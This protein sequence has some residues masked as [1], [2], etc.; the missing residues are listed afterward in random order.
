MTA[1]IGPQGTLGARVSYVCLDC[2]Q[3]DRTLTIY[4]LGYITYPVRYTGGG[5]REML[6]SQENQSAIVNRFAELKKPVVIELFETSLNCRTCAEVKQLLQEVAALSDLLTLET[7]NTITDEANVKWMN[8]DGAP[9]IRI[10]DETKINSGVHFYGAPSGYEFATLLEGI[11]MVSRR[12][13]GLQPTTRAALA[14][15]KAP[16]DLTVFVTPTCP[17]CPRAVHLAHQFAYESAMVTGNMVES[18]EFSDW[19]EQFHVYGVP[20]TVMNDVESLSVEGAV[21]EQSLLE[22]VLQGAGA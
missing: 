3:Q 19:S 5:A 16:V 8:L 7:Y 13:S 14:A 9:F 6:L 11:L 20:K 4:Q 22:L 21:P 1:N 10:T 17:Y 2:A 12:E 18:T 15:L